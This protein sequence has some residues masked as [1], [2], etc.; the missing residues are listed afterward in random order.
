MDIETSPLWM[1]ENAGACSKQSP[2]DP[3]CDWLHG[4]RSN[5][6]CADASGSAVPPGP[7][8]RCPHWGDTKVPCDHSWR[9]L[10]S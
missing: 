1:W 5:A 2:N 8:T 4:H 9:E 7:R 6:T 3:S 10:A